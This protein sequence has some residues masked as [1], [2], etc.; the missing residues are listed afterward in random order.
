M[1]A[2]CA[3]F[4]EPPWLYLAFLMSTEEVNTEELFTGVLWEIILLINIYL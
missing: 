4:G 1:K 2:H 3:T